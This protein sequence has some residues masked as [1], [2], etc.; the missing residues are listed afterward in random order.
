SAARVR[1]TSL[2]NMH[3]LLVRIGLEGRADVS[4]PRGR[5]RGCRASRKR[6]QSVSV[7]ETIFGGSKQQPRLEAAPK[8]RYSRAL[9]L[10]DWTMVRGPGHRR[11]APDVAR[12]ATAC[13]AISG[14]ASP[15]EAW[16]YRRS[17]RKPNACTAPSSV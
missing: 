1:P 11:C 9:S 3:Y 12:L 8:W 6:G 4:G 15:R 17:S 13:D 2:R 16:C 10:K 14:S 7:R 5:G